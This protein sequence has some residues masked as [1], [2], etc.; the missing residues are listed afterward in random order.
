MSRQ[1]IIGRYVWAM[2][3]SY[4]CAALQEVVARGYNIVGQQFS[5]DEVRTENC[6]HFGQ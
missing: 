3:R 2:A 4:P 5:C 6:S 1:V